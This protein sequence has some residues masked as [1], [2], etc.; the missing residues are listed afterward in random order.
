MILAA[1]SSSPTH[2]SFKVEYRKRPLDAL[3]SGWMG[4]S[5]PWCSVVH[6]MDLSG[7]L[8]GNALLVLHILNQDE[9]FGV[10]ASMENWGDFSQDVMQYYGVNLMCLEKQYKEEQRGYYLQT[11]CWA[12]IHPSQLLGP[13]T[14]FKEYDLLT[15]TLEELA[16]P[17]KV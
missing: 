10:Q 13:P 11:T 15:I 1:L 3:G 16:A 14:C 7:V 17:L 2:N 9:S 5:L 8:Q 4:Q 6:P 12:D